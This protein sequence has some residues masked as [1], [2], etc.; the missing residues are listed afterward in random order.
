MK[1]VHRNKYDLLIG[2]DSVELFDYFGVNEL[3]GLKRSEAVNY[4]ETNDDLYI[5][6]MSNYHPS[7]RLL[8]KYPKPYTFI[9]RKAL[10][11]DFR[12]IT[13]LTHELTHQALLQYDWNMD[14]EEEIISWVEQ[15]ANYILKNSLIPSYQVPGLI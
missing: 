2:D 5:A 9:N 7:D 8:I 15:Q 14:Y 1:I 4:N 3:H 13:L 6:G 10:K 12:G 11:N